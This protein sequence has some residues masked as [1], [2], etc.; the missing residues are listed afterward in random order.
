MDTLRAYITRGIKIGEGNFGEVYKSHDPVHGDVAVKILH[1]PTDYHPQEWQSRK[2]ELLNEA[3]RLKEAEHKNI[4][5]VYSILETEDKN[6]LWLV[7]EYCS[8]GSLISSYRQGPMELHPLRSI[9]TDVALG[10]QAVH[11]RGMFHRDIKP[12]NILL[13]ASGRAKLGD[14][15]LV[16]TNVNFGYG[17]VGG[18]VNHLAKE[19]FELGISSIRTDIWAFGMTAYRML[20]GEQF[21][22]EFCEVVGEPKELVQLG[23]FARRLQWLPHVPDDWRRF[24]RRTMHDDSSSRYQ[25]AE[26]LQ[27]AL[28]RLT[29]EPDWC[30]EYT[31]SRVSWTNKKGNRLRQ[32]TWLKHSK[33]R[34][35]WEAKSLPIRGVGRAVRLRGTTGVVGRSQAER[36][37]K[38]YFDESR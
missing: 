2:L 17:Q 29:V 20:H 26:Q 3:K 7:M 23:G 11:A 12:S 8:G 14:F 28:A 1:C 31:N 32:V 5:R 15:G 4:V 35:E 18:Y 16:T 19:C 9:L 6:A 30:V 13:D 37:L 27:H 22:K 33:R 36:E 24:I 25:S 21:Y 34:N 10:L 38:Q